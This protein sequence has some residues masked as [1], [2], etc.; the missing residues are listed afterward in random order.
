MQGNAG[1]VVYKLDFPGIPPDLV[2]SNFFSILKPRYF[3]FDSKKVMVFHFKTFLA[4]FEMLSEKK[5]N[6]RKIKPSSG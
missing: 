6:G 3:S 4:F 2:T 1:G 5:K